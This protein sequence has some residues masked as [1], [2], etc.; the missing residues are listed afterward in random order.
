[1]QKRKLGIDIDGTITCPTSFIP[2][3]NQSFNLNLTL[4]DLTVYDLATIIGISSEEFYKWMKTAEPTIY[5]NAKMVDDYV[6]SVLNKWYDEHQLIFISARNNQYFDITQSWFANREVPY[7][8]IELIGKHDKL[9]AVRKHEVEVFFEDKHDNACEISEECNIPVLLF[10]TP[11]NQEPIPKNV[12][13]VNNWKEAKDW[14]EQ[15]F[16]STK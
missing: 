16:Q 14:V 8:H 12:I 11:Y 9:E 4:K 2:Y 3:I 6:M 13:R 5:T 15:H 1:M 10:N 7:H